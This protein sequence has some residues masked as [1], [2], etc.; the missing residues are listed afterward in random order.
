MG[1]VGEP[2]YVGMVYVQDLGF[3]RNLRVDP[4]ELGRGRMR[5]GEVC[6]D[7]VFIEEYLPWFMEQLNGPRR[8]ETVWDGLK[9]RGLSDSDVETLASSRMSADFDHLDKLID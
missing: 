5:F 1:T 2:L 8:M 7:V 6:G 4:P 3:D 9:S